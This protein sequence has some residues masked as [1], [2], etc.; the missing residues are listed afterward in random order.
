MRI[1]FEHDSDGIIYGLNK[2]IFFARENQY[3]FGANCV[4]W[5]AGIIGLD[6]ELTIYIDNQYTRRPLSLG[7][8]DSTRLSRTKEI[9]PTP[10]GIGRSVS[11]ELNKAKDTSNIRNPANKSVKIIKKFKNRKRRNNNKSTRHYMILFERTESTA[12]LVAKRIPKY[13]RNSIIKNKSMILGYIC[14]NKSSR[15]IKD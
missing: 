4:W 10:R 11:V 1:T 15:H 6:T 12:V 2:I 5:I 8:S 9:P 7:Q 13:P 3:L 14:R